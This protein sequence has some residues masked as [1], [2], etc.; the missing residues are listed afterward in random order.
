MKYIPRE[1]DR[2]EWWWCVSAVCAAPAGADVV[3][4]RSGGR[5][6]GSGGRV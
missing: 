6:C 5:V 3:L 2:A 4:V 1:R